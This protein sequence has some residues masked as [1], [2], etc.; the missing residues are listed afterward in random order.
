METTHERLDSSSPEATDMLYL[1]QDGIDYT[2]T[3]YRKGENPRS[4]RKFR[5]RTITSSE[6][7]T[8][9]RKAAQVDLVHLI[10][11]TDVEEC[12]YVGSRLPPDHGYPFATI[13]PAHWWAGLSGAHIKAGPLADKSRIRHAEVTLRD[14]A[15]REAAEA[16]RKTPKSKAGLALKEEREKMEEGL[17]RQDAG[18]PMCDFDTEDRSGE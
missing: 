12:Y 16:R 18:L 4:I 3:C 13:A 2:R 1:I 6:T 14:K 10:W 8:T 5:I 15:K 11:S 9:L 7:L 17:R